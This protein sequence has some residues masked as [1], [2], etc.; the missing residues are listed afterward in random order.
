MDGFKMPESFFLLGDENSLSFSKEVIPSK[1][2]GLI[3]GLSKK[4]GDFPDS[5]LTC[6]SFDSDLILLLSSFYC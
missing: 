3:T 1:L 4:V 5:L 6:D 2:K